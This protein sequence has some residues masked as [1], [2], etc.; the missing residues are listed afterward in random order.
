[1]SAVDPSRPDIVA[2]MAAAS[3]ALGRDLP[4]PKDVFNFGGSSPADADERLLLA[5]QGK[6]TATTSWPVPDPLYW[7]VGDLSVILDGSG[8][9]RALM[10]TVSFV[11][12]RFRDV[13]ED[14]ALAEAE[15][16][17]ETYRTG[18]IDFYR[19]Q[20]NGEEFGEDS[21]VL[22]ERFEVIYSTGRSEDVGVKE[23][24]N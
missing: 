21:V 2:F 24:S 4:A 9:P 1:M 7:G 20:E 8:A 16:D 15:G 5:I 11:Q 12:C 18:H 23:V 17:Y 6:K 13:D 19:R 10:R 3:S 22:C 14:F